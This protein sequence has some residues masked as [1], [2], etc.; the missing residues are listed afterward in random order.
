LFGY[1]TVSEV[2]K[3]EA[4]TMLRRLALC[5]VGF[6]ML[7]FVTFVFYFIHLSHISPTQPDLITGQVVHMN[8][9]GHDFYV[10]PWQGW[11]L[12]AAPYA[13]LGALVVIAGIDQRLNWNLAADMTPPPSW[14]FWLFLAAVVAIYAFFGFP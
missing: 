10:Y 13:C 1:C 8:N 2:R 3:D 14:V 12:Q 5:F 7:G 9:H 11:V 6:A 4:E